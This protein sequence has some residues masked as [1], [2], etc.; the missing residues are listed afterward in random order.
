MSEIKLIPLTLKE[1]N[2]KQPLIYFSK[3]ERK[4]FCDFNNGNLYA[5][6]TAIDGCKYSTFQ[7]D[8]DEVY[9]LQL[10]DEQ[11]GT[12]EIHHLLWPFITAKY[13]WDE[14]IN[15]IKPIK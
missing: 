11:A 5:E 14:L 3:S 6:K 13:G 2:D 1:F 15:G 7:D 10:F 9:K 8:I 12:I 4:V